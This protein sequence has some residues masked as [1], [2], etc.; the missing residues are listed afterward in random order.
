MHHQRG[1]FLFC[2]LTP[3]QVHRLRQEKGIYIPSNGRLN[4][5]GLN[6]QNIDYVAE[7]LLAV[8]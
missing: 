1:L 3:E 8:L 2:G 6:T 4:I 7:S 5:A